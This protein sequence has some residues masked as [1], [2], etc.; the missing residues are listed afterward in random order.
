MRMPIAALPPVL[1]GPAGDAPARSGPLALRKL[2]ALIA[3]ASAGLTALA[4]LVVAPRLRVELADIGHT[5]RLRKPFTGLGIVGRIAV[6][7]WRAR[8]IG[9]RLA[10]TVAAHRQALPAAASA[11]LLAARAATPFTSPFTSP[12]TALFAAPAFSAATPSARRRAAIAPH[13]LTRAGI[14]AEGVVAHGLVELAA[15]AS[16]AEAA[17]AIA[18][19]RM[20]ALAER[21]LVLAATATLAVDIGIAPV[22]V[23]PIVF[24]A[25]LGADWVTKIPCAP[26]CPALVHVGLRR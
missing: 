8:L 13:H 4:V 21:V 1:A 23:A 2:A 18:A 5:V 20:P 22:L 14:G 17:G 24:Q 3:P 6:P 11:K 10:R 12:F 16:L 15:K 9:P 25:V 26:A 19:L 7:P